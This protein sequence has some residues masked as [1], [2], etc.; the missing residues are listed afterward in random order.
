VWQ[1]GYTALLLACWNGDADLARWLL[2]SAGSNARLESENVRCVQCL[3]CVICV[4]ERTFEVACEQEGYTALLLACLGGH[5]DLTRWLV[6][7]A[8]SNP[9]EEEDEVR[10]TSYLCLAW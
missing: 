10:R 7:S 2:T 6:S 3:V 1:F 9:Q 4:R 5:A 8:G